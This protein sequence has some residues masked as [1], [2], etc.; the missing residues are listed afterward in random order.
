MNSYGGKTS[1]LHWNGMTMFESSV[2]SYGGKTM[3][4]E[5]ERKR[6][7]ESSANLYGSNNE[8]SPSKDCWHK[9]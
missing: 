6:G 9:R 4:Q 2:N 7:F 5:P 8:K 1:T 3:E